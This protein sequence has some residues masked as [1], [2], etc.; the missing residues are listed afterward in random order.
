MKLHQVLDN[1]LLAERVVDWQIKQEW[2][3]VGDWLVEP[4]SKI[5]RPE[6]ER[7]HLQ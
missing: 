3:V 6:I 5:W 2:C 4:G 1:V 7:G